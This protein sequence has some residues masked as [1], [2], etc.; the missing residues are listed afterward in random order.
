MPRLGVFSGEQIARIMESQGFM[1]VRQK[2][3]H[4]IMQ[5]KDQHTIT[6]PV[7]MHREVRIG[8]LQSI[9]RQSQLSKD[10]FT[11]Q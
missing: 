1:R 3:S 7:P 5:K 6:V 2:G 10:L 9:I 11:V 8:T 4:L